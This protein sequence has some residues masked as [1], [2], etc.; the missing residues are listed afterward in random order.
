MTD[1]PA[2][3]LDSPVAIGGVGGSGT[4]LF[5]RILL[6]LGFHIGSDLNDSLDNLW[7][8]LLF[9]RPEVLDGSDADF[10]SLFTIFRKAMH[11]SDALSEAEIRLIR[12]AA[13]EPR[14]QHDVEWLSQRAESL[15]RVCAGPARQNPRWGWKAPNT[16]IVLPQ[17]S[18]LVPGIR[19]IHIARN[20]L[21]MAY[22]QN[23]NQLETWGTR[24]LGTDSI[25]VTPRFSLKYWV[26]V[27][28]RVI[29][30]ARHMKGRFLLVNYDVLCAD[31][32][33]K[34]P[35]L[36]EFLGFDPSPARLAAT[37]KLVRSPAGIGRFK[38]FPPD[39]FDPQDVAFVR[40]MGFDTEW[41]AT[42]CRPT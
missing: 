41:P 13:A 12:A 5:A 31:P 15:V 3:R 40:R 32:W 11:G 10:C 36:I 21:D 42:V 14:P 24:F 16:H 28:R 17:L 26:A 4:R 9:K 6:E 33:G 19:Y 1:A 2:L 7:F 38:A 23:Q 30:T 35:A 37:A 20:G 25:A 29:E 18:N 22:S 34:L 27:H 39:H 8:P